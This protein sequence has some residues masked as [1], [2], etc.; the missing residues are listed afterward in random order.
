M[1][2]PSFETPC[3]G[4]AGEPAGRDALPWPH[5]RAAELTRRL[6]AL[7][8]SETITWTLLPSHETAFI[9]YFSDASSDDYRRLEGFCFQ[10][11]SPEADL[12]AVD[13]AIRMTHG[14][15][16]SGE[17]FR[18]KER[19]PQI[20]V[21]NWLWDNHVSQLNNLRTA[22][23]ADINFPS[24][25]YA[26]TYLLNPAAAMGAH[27][28]ACAAQWSVAE[29]EAAVQSEYGREPSPK[30]LVNY[31]DYAWSWRS[32]LLRRL[33]AEVVEAE[34]LL[35]PPDDRSR[36]FSRTPAERFAEWQRYKSTLILPVDRDLSTR[37]FDAL[38]AGQVVIAPRMIADF[39][40]VIPPAEQAR[41]GIIRIGDY[42][43]P[44]IRQAMLIAARTFDA[45]GR[46][47]VVARHQF[48]ASGHMIHHRLHTILRTISPRHRS[49][50]TLRFS[51][52]PQVPPCLVWSR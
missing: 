46:E 1:N 23:A 2:E 11:Y 48:V 3:M 32:P 43:L 40:A 21:A 35:M 12:S 6:A 30:T 31:V 49:S 24:H 22:F 29:A 14:G 15:D 50:A 28:P 4:P 41:L 44:T 5:A 26:A 27:V 36:Y 13:V 9:R 7:A 33:Q 34:V 25:N 8:A 18:L 38:L 52:E 17:L 47:G 16:N 20:I 10:P 37:V 39:D 19:F 51:T 42:E 45:M